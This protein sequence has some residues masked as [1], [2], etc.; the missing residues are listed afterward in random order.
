MLFIKMACVLVSTCLI[1]MQRRVSAF[2]SSSSSSVL[3]S[4]AST[5]SIKSIRPMISSSSLLLTSKSRNMNELV[6][7]RLSPLRMVSSG[8]PLPLLYTNNND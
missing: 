4:L 2:R 8:I 1:M 3:R 7:Y 6:S 5:K